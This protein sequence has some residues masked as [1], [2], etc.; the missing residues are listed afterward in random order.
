MTSIDINR[1]LHESV[2][3]WNQAEFVFLEPNPWWAPSVQALL[4]GDIEAAAGG[5]GVAGSAGD[6]STD[7]RCESVSSP[8]AIHERVQ[9]RPLAGVVLMVGEQVRDCLLGRLSRLG[10]PTPP[11][12]MVIPPTAVSLLPML[13][14]SGASSV[15]VEGVTDLQIADWCRRAACS[16]QETAT[17]R[18]L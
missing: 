7:Y 5:G 8:R 9:S 18:S 6:P 4:A 11:V 14:E 1:I 13:L 17:R 15:M 3:L 16:G 2:P 10:R 12:L